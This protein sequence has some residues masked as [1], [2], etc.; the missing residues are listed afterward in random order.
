MRLASYAS[1]TTASVLIVVKL[2]AWQLTD[3]MSLLAALIDSLLDVAASLVNLYAV[4]QAL[5]PPDSQHRFGHGKAEPLA[6]LG[7]SAFITGSA[8][9]LFIEASHRLFEPRDLERAGIAIGV[10]VFSIAATLVLVTFQHYVV[11]RSGSIAIK[12]DSLHY[13]GDLLMNLAVIVAIVLTTELGWLYA[14]PLFGLGI[15]LYII[16]NAWLIARGSLDMLMDRELPD[17]QRAR[18]RSIVMDNPEILG[19]HDLRT[20]ESGPQIFIQCHIELDGQQSLFDA[21]EVAD[22]VELQLRE[23][24]PGAEVI[25]HQDPYLGPQHERPAP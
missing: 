15:A 20:R 17:G 2:A 11:K 23:A 4:R 5:Q 9:F 14:D 12:A 1:V 19:L 7:Q 13:K 21:H 10:M 24:Y 18:I 3:S 25:I 6:S 8:I 16:Y 22:R